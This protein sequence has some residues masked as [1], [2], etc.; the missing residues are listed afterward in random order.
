MKTDKKIELMSEDECASSPWKLLHEEQPEDGEK[1]YWGYLRR[2]GTVAM[3]EDFDDGDN[4]WSE[5]HVDWVYMDGFDEEGGWGLASP[6]NL[7]IDIYWCN[8]SAF[9]SW[10]KA[11][12]S[13]VTLL[14][15]RGCRA[16][17]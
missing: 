13:L 4:V 5:Y 1:C 15:D 7:P 9:P 3:P 6:V 17:W 16:S 2:D 12:A 14:N 10:G 11:K 8:F